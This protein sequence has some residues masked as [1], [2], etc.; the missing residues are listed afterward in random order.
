V[1]VQEDTVRVQ[2][3]DTGPGVASA[4]IARIFE[5]YSR[6]G[7]EGVRGTG[8]GL[9]IASMLVEQMGS[10]LFIESTLGDGSTF[11]F[12]LAAST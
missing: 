11:W 2:V 12:D 9:A 5:P 7:N 1:E 3:S 10:Q 6:V 4:D 8:L